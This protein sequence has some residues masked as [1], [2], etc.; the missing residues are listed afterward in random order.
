MLR[1]ETGI[2]RTRQALELP[3]VEVKYIADVRDAIT[4]NDL[5][6]GIPNPC[7]NLRVFE[8]G[9]VDD[10]PDTRWTVKALVREDHQTRMLVRVNDD[11][12]RAMS[13]PDGTTVKGRNVVQLANELRL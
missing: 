2:P 5:E 7:L 12:H 3:F 9:N 1:I 6:V 10:P 8:I 4:G 13:R 11:R